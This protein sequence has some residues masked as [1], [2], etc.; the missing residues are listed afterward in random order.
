LAPASPT[1]ASRSDV[2]ESED[3][4]VLVA[5]VSQDSNALG[6]FGLSYYE[7]KAEQMKAIAVD[8]GEGAVLPSVE[9]VE[10]AQYQPLARPLFVYVN[11]AATRT[12]SSSLS[13]TSLRLAPASPTMASVK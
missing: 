4:D 11:A 2:T 3:D 10:Q 6:Y 1:M 12:S 13:V 8:S 5:G 9:T 7:Q